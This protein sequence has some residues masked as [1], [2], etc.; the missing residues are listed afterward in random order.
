MLSNI[1]DRVACS[2]IEVFEN[3][4]GAAL[5]SA[6]GESCAAMFGGL[7]CLRVEVFKNTWWCSVASILASLVQRVVGGG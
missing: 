7:L 3:L 6:F 4:G 2:R 5:T 1:R